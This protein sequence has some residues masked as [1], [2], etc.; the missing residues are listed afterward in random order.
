MAN[1]MIKPRLAII[2]TGNIAHF[3]C[4]AFTKAGFDI[5]HAAGSLNSKKVEEFGRQHAIKNIFS[6]PND[7]LKNHKEWDLLLLS[8][9]TEKNNDYINKIL[10]LEKPVLIEKPVAINPSDLLR[11]KKKKEQLALLLWSKGQ[12]SN[13]LCPHMSPATPTYMSEQVMNSAVSIGAASQ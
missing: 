12:R 5:S 7:V 13:F 3:H 1:I 9:P 10:D 11:F 2:G 6:N 8:P 4:E